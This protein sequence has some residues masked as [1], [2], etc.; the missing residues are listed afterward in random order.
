MSYDGHHCS[1]SLVTKC[2]SSSSYFAGIYLTVIMAMSAASVALAVFVLNCHHR[3]TIVKL[4][5]KPVQI[6]ATVVGRLLCMKLFY[7]K[8]KEIPSQPDWQPNHPLDLPRSVCNELMEIEVGGISYC[9][10]VFRNTLDTVD[11]KNAVQRHAVEHLRTIISDYQKSQFERGVV[12]VWREVAHV[13]DRCFFVVFIS[14]TL[15]SSVVLLVVR[16]LTKATRL[17]DLI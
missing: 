14:I 7:L 9:S 1:A 5:P 4:P 11:A 15:V 10:S 13:M 2:K 17:A 8:V 6:L 12:L 16:P 3:S